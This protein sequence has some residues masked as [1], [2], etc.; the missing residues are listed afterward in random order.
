MFTEDNEDCDV[1]SP[2]VPI[3]LQL[4]AQLG[5]TLLDRNHELEQALQHM[6]TTNDE[7]LQEIGVT[8]TLC[9]CCLE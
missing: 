8:C 6:Y 3:D 2:C 5:K 1:V 7:Q 4:A 9:F